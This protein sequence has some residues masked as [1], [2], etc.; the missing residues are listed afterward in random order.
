MNKWKKV[1]IEID[2]K[3]NE[4]LDK[5]YVSGGKEGMISSYFKKLEFIE[6]NN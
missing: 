2:V 4:D 1:V 6:F 5:R 3:E